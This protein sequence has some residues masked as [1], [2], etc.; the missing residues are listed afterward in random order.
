MGGTNFICNYNATKIIE[1]LTDA[2]FSHYF[3]QQV[4]SQPAV[5]F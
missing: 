4:L 1:T 3:L 2:V 5:Q